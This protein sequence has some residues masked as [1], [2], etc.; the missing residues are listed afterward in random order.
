MVKFLTILVL[1]FT[2]LYPITAKEE[3]E[4]GCFLLSK[5]KYSEAILKFKSAIS[6]NPYY[7]EAYN[8]LGLVY[9]QKKEYKNAIT[10]FKKAISLDSSYTEAYNNL[11]LA[12]EMTGRIDDAI[13][14]YQIA[15]KQ[16]PTNPEFHYNLGSSLYKK[17][18][19]FDA[20]KEYKK[21]IEIEPSFYSSYIR[22]GDIYWND[23]K[24]KEEAIMYYEDAKAKNPGS[25]L[26]HLGLGRLYFQTKEIQKAIWEYKKAIQKNK[27]PIDELRELG[28]IY[29]EKGDYKGAASLYKRLLSLK[30]QDKVAKYSLGLIYEKM[31]S[32]SDALSM[33]EDGLKIEKDEVLQFSKEGLISLL[34]EP[35]YSERRKEGSILH[36]K[37]GEDY[38]KKGII[39]LAVY[40]HKRAIS[41]N[42]LDLKTRFSLARIYEKKE[43]F[44]N[45]EDELVKII[46][47]EPASIEASDMVERINFKKKKSIVYQEKIDEI[48]EPELRLIFFVISKSPLIYPDSLNYF[49]NLL[50]TLL[51]Y[52]KKLSLIGPQEF[53][54]DKKIAIEKAKE[55]GA[56][57]LLFAEIKEGEK[58][59]KISARLIDMESLKEEE[60]ISFGSGDNRIREAIYYLSERIEELLPIKGKIFKI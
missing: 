28:N 18:Q 16:D 22:L 24:M 6:K 9:C 45:A 25:P 54:D 26:P 31:G 44:S 57:F 58:E 1:F 36:L 21:T 4:E 48:P 17:G 38:L 42:P 10:S 11:G 30:P 20:I 2:N 7:K 27:E 43:M 35:T 3:Y 52:S 8:K 49:D 5:A 32:F 53:T 15:I 19:I 46:E 29:I 12:Y 14:V 13:K 51:S 40:E 55:K 56:D 39:K 59:I 37:S 34:N 50:K 47:L 41:L 23:K 60:I 33:Y